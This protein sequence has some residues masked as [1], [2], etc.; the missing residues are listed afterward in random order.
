MFGLLGVVLGEL[1][2]RKVRHYA[3]DVT[4]AEHVDCRANSVA[5]FAEVVVDVDDDRVVSGW[6]EWTV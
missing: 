3:R 5:V 4:V 1:V 6:V 2:L